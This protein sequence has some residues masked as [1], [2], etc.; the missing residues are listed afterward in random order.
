MRLPFGSLIP[1]PSQCTLMVMSNFVGLNDFCVHFPILLP[2]SVL[3]QHMIRL[4]LHFPFLTTAVKNQAH[5][6]AYQQALEGSAAIPLKYLKVL[7]FG[8]PRTGKTAMRRRLVGEIQNLAGKRVQA[9][10]D[11][12]DFKMLIIKLVSCAKA[13]IFRKENS[14][15]KTGKSVQASQIEKSDAIVNPGVDKTVTLTAVITKS[16]SSSIMNPGKDKTVS[17]KAKSEWSSLCKEKSTDLDEECRLLYQFIYGEKE[18]QA[19]L[20][21]VNSSQESSVKSSQESSE[22]SSVGRSSV[23]NPDDA[24]AKISDP[25]SPKANPSTQ[26]DEMGIEEVDKVFKAIEKVLHTPG[27]EKLKVLLDGTVFVN[28]IDMGGQPAFLEMLPALTIGS[29]LYLIFFRL[30]Q[31]LKTRYPV[32]YGEGGKNVTFDDSYTNEEVIFQ[33]LSSIAC[34]HHTKPDPTVFRHLPKPFHAAMLMGTHKDELGKGQKSVAEEL[35]DK[36]HELEGTLGEIRKDFLERASNDHLMLAVDNM[37]G[38]ETELEAV[39]KRL[40]DIINLTLKGI[41]IPA[42]WLMFGIF[43]RKMNKPRLHLSQCRE[44]GRRLNVRDTNEALWFLHHYV[45]NLMHFSDVPGIED[46]VI[47]DPQVVFD[48]V[49]N[50][51]L[52]S[53]ELSEVKTEVCDRFKKTGRFSFANIAVDTK[54]SSSILSRRQL[55]KLLEHLNVIAPIQCSLPQQDAHPAGKFSPTF[56][57]SPQSDT[58]QAEKEYFMPA[59]LKCA[60]ENELHVEHSSVDPVPLMIRFKCGLVPV[61]VPVGVF[62]AMI[63]NLVAQKWSLVE[64]SGSS[65]LY[66][67]I[68][69]FRM[70][71][72]Y[73]ITLVSRLKWYE[74]HVARICKSKKTIADVCK[75]VRETVCTALDQVVSKMNH[76]QISSSNQTLHELGFQCPEHLGEEDYDGHLVTPKGES[77]SANLWSN[78]LETEPMMMICCRTEMIIKDDTL[79]SPEQ[80]HVWFGKVSELC[81]NPILVMTTAVIYHIA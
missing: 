53:F 15:H 52:N 12:A 79:I 16:K 1:W 45:G 44:I 64:P 47:C 23:T 70:H 2:E 49:T 5:Y 65:S 41:E 20:S 32:L 73:Y 31:E 24:K 51:I 72:A 29:A 81:A 21:S 4:Q 7:F 77:Q 10:T 55:V 76:N 80:H 36:S 11:I 58:H 6:E 38:D 67:N 8:P 13:V 74:I 59:V 60:T 43:I 48:S 71:N 19:E 18:K 30:D 39:K 33:A 63:A 35:K 26:E 68:V 66:K 34:F 25:K 9:S 22:K 78:N 27:Q 3:P 28:M 56:G 42:S 54:S 50:L 40:E 62:C 75:E 69:K 14:S 46:I 61:G 57:P 37:N 17:S